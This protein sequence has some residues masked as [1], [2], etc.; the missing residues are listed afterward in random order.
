MKRNTTTNYNSVVEHTVSDLST[1][2]WHL[3]FQ[4]MPQVPTASTCNP[5]SKAHDWGS[6]DE[7]WGSYCLQEPATLRR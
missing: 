2:S 3:L 7:V 6:R 5:P 1:F 4:Q